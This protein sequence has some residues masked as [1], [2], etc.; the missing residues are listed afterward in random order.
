MEMLFDNDGVVD[1]HHHTIHGVTHACYDE[2]DHEH[3]E[4]SEEENSNIVKAL[5]IIWTNF[6]C[7]E[8]VVSILGWINGNI[9]Y[10]YLF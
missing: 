9:I 6:T 2:H 3:T 8:S 7:V 4:K 5:L 10:H 1:H